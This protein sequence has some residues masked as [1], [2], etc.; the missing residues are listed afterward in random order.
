[1]F[2]KELND[3]YI[4]FLNKYPN[5]DYNIDKKVLDENYVKGLLYQIDNNEIINLLSKTIYLFNKEKIKQQRI[6]EKLNEYDFEKFIEPEKIITILRYMYYEY[7]IPNKEFIDICKTVLDYD[8][9]KEFAIYL[10]EKEIIKMLDND[11]LSLAKNGIMLTASLGFS[12]NDE[13]KD[14][15]VYSIKKKINSI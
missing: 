15:Y 2:D 8:I 14:V 10:L 1:M 3:L 13:D 7:E 5:L 12:L 11:K 6:K 9:E 4:E